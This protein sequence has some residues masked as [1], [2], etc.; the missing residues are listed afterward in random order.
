MERIAYSVQEVAEMVGISQQSLYNAIR[1]GNFPA[2]RLGGRYVIF[3][4]DFEEWRQ[5]SK[6]QQVSN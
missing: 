2:N 1:I 6:R 3:K 5:T 4:A